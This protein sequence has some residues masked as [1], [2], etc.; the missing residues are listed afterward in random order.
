MT[1]VSV[2]KKP[3]TFQIDK[4]DAIYEAGGQRTGCKRSKL[5]VTISNTFEVVYKDE[6]GKHVIFHPDPWKNSRTTSRACEDHGGPGRNKP[7][8]GKTPSRATARVGR[9]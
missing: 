8:S 5:A 1:L 6:D 9:P 7:K 4:C 2:M 3:V